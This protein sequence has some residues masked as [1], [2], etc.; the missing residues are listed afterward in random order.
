MVLVAVNLT[1]F[2]ATQYL[3]SSVLFLDMIGTAFA[4]LTKGLGY[5][6]VVGLASNFFGQFLPAGWFPASYDPDS[7]RWFALA[8][9]AGAVSWCILP[10]LWIVGSDRFNWWPKRDIFLPNPEFGY[11]QLLWQI[12]SVGT[13]AG[14]VVALVGFA[15]QQLV[16]GCGANPEICANASVTTS[17][18]SSISQ[19]FA[20][21]LG[22]EP[23][24]RIL[25]LLAFNVVDKILT[26]AAAIALALS[27]SHL[28]DYRK[29]MEHL[30]GDAYPRYLASP[31]RKTA[32][33]LYVIFWT[34]FLT[35][36]INDIPYDRDHT[37]TLLACLGFFMFLWVP[38][39]FVREV[40]LYNVFYQNDPADK[41]LFHD[42]AAL[43][44]QSFQRDVLEDV[45]KMFTVLLGVVNIL[46]VEG[47][48][49]VKLIQF[50]RTI[51]FLTLL[52]Y[53]LVFIMRVS[54]RFDQLAKA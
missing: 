20:S 14:I 47:N 38:L 39:W 45:F 17:T 24:A 31:I 4:S 22:N 42:I 29:Q 44:G 53:L 7:Y 12:C 49:A 46:F 3:G 26:T 30:R 5:G 36:Y 10:R 41:K 51:I 23:S 28:P 52:R 21:I 2:V 40:P 6:V 25:T 48:A 15:I 16:L 27:L 35:V 19:A 33:V 32:V 34:L 50:A 43:R 13:I 1:G 18:A 8:N 37:A 54:G 11:R 9:V